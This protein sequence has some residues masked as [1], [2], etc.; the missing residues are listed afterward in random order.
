MVQ[1]THSTVFCPV[2]LCSG[3]ANIQWFVAFEQ[4]IVNVQARIKLCW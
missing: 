4:R 2:P 1:V 3:S